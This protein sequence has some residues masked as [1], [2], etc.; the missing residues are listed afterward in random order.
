M[1]IE[2]FLP[3]M[4]WGPEDAPGVPDPGPSI[5][6]S[7][8]PDA[9]GTD[10]TASFALD[11]FDGMSND[12]DEIDDTTV[13]DD[14]APAAT[15]SAPVGGA[16]PPQNQPAVTPTGAGAQA[17]AQ[18]QPAAP[19]Q[20]QGQATPPA[21][22]PGQPTGAAPSAP[23]SPSAQGNSDQIFSNLGRMIEENR[24]AFTNALAEKAYQLSPEDLAELDT[25]PAKVISQVAARV[26]VQAT[27]S[28]MKVFS[29]QMPVYVNQLVQAQ[30]VNAER[31]G[32]FWQANPGLNRS[33]HGD[34]V[35]SIA[36][37]Y[38]DHNPNFTE[39]EFTQT[40]GNMAMA[41]LGLTHAAL[42][43]AAA[44]QQ[45]PAPHQGSVVQ[46]PGRVV[47]QVAP[48]APVGGMH[49]APGTGRAP[50]RNEW[51]TLANMMSTYDDN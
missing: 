8:I 6:A 20:P 29:Q 31:E 45:Q 44:T 48:P 36:S 2:K 38:R 26:H 3:K 1:W 21:G 23:E 14:V 9:R 35:R 12:Y 10:E 28:L 13:V 32:R 37:W 27:E 49:S 46:T 4:V 5:P 15:P 50:A 16:Q 30:A 39:A 11:A 51:D 19:G 17:P 7:D 40:V 47:R 18:Q 34:I 33:L 43:Q 41:R 42:Q 24:Q 22:Q 25:N